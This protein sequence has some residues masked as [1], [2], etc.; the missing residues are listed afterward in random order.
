M[1]GKVF[2]NRT[3]NLK[4][5]R[6]IGVDMDH[7]LVRYNSENFERL[8]HTT[9][10]DKLV[11]RGY[12]ETLRKLV[13]DYNFAIRGLV[14]DRK[15]GNLLKLNRYTAIRASYHGLKPLDFKSHQKLYKS[16]YID[17]SNSDYLAV[18]TSFSISL[19]NLI[20][21]IVELKDN[22][23]ANKYPEY[24]QIADDVLDALDEAHRD[25]SLKD[26]VKQNLDHYIIKDPSIV[27]TLEKFRRH[28]KKIFVLTNSDF[29][30][31]KLLLDYAV[32]PFLKEH[33]SWADLFEFVIT[34]ASK[35]KFFYENQKYLIVNP[36]DGSMTN[37]EGKLTP[38]IYQ[39]GNAKKFT[40][41]LGLDGDDIL[42]VGDHIYGDILRL[43]KD[44]N[45]RTAMVI[46][47]L[48]VEVENNRK[49]E[50]IN[51]EIETLMKKKEPLEDELTDIMTRKI[52]KEVPANEPQIETLQKTISEIDAQISQLIKKQQA[53]YNG[54]WGQL[55]RAG[56]EE[57]YFAYQLDRYACVYMQKL[58]DLLDLSPRTYFRAPR[59]PLAHEIF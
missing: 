3:L 24:A 43:K 15:M 23:T 42:Y 12:P 4:K 19:A 46:E 28:G 37:M 50:P 9:M 59:R 2:V 7:T 51:Q 56:N 1:P 14:I 25:G 22:D 27:A 57:S 40:S 39:G 5:I 36:V 44:C 38:G 30:Y 41:D 31:T 32:Q 49:A 18:D 10:I 35:P 6:Y 52:E 48:D 29:H 55:M 21:Q 16:T 45:W 26:V 20:A 11:K 54:N 58:S 33:K 13:F 8:S 34:F 17:L 53:M 47:E